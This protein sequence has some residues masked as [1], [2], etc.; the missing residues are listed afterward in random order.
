MEDPWSDRVYALIRAF[1]ADAGLPATPLAQAMRAYFEGPGRL[2]VGSAL[3]D[4][5]GTVW[6]RPLGP[7]RARW[8]VDRSAG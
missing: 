6:L 4:R 1:A 5:C 2:Q 7:Q 3:D 8:Y